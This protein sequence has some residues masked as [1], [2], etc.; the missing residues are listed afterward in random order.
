[1]AY[2]CMVTSI[3]TLEMSHDSG[4]MVPK[5]L[6]VMICKVAYY[7]KSDSYHYG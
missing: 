2:V 1:M 4:K 7:S 6:P 3:A 5:N